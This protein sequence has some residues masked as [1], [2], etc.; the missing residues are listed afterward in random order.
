M[1]QLA[2][3]GQNELSVPL[4]IELFHRFFTRLLEKESKYPLYLQEW[5]SF[6]GVLTQE[7]FSIDNAFV[8]LAKI[9]LNVEKGSTANTNTTLSDISPGGNNFLKA[10][11][12]YKINVDSSP[13][14]GKFGRNP[15]SY[16]SAPPDYANQ[17]RVSIQ[18]F[19]EDISKLLDNNNLSSYLIP[20]YASAS[21]LFEN[22]NDVSII[23]TKSGE[24]QDLPRS[25]K[26]A[27]MFQIT[28]GLSP[29]RIH[30][31]SFI[32]SKA[33][34]LKENIATHSDA[35]VENSQNKKNKAFGFNLEERTPLRKF[36]VYAKTQEQ[37]NNGMVLQNAAEQYSL[38][39]QSNPKN[40]TYHHITY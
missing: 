27:D 20:S 21:G 14:S 36:V 38:K 39:I 28:F 8:Q 33:R 13:K 2:P 31:L 17:K 22:A 12:D 16:L 3:Q 19:N 15:K 4:A 35:V 5:T 18:V 25:T 32:T 1:F 6:K 11:G 40:P 26:A 9:Q 7:P 30:D 10:L 34:M 37:Q 29:S 24:V 23:K